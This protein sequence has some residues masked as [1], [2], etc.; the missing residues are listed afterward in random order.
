LS[1]AGI[2]S[3]LTPEIM[4]WRGENIGIGEGEGQ[5]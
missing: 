3:R 2:K 5:D 4:E 1:T